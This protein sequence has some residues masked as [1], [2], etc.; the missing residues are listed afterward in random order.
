VNTRI[1]AVLFDLGNTLVGYYPAE[2]FP[3]VLRR[4][5][6][7]C[8]ET[9]GWLDNR[10]REEKLLASALQ[11]NAER[12]DFSV[13]VLDVRLRELFATYGPL[14]DGTLQ[15]ICRAFTRPIFERAALDPEALP[16]L[17]SLRALGLRTAIV[18]NTPWGSAADVWREE[19]ARHGLL[20]RVDASV[21]CVEV[22]Y[23]KP[24]RA[25]FERAL[26]LLDVAPADA[27]FVGDDCRWDII[28]AQNAG[29]RPV[30]LRPQPASAVDGC[31]AIQK[32]SDVA[33]LVRC[34]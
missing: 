13:R 18:S 24:H 28:G 32:L 10:E 4:C 33:G 12:P 9:L 25:P 21:F 30:L 1:R 7:G 19:L 29:L 5:L 11:L 16:L 22:G 3:Q 23:R 15:A 20:E 26:A 27:I 17:E 6:R 34:D 14:D 2:E 31:V 8:A